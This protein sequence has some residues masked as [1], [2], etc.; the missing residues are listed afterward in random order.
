MLAVSSDELA[1][2]ADNA[3]WYLQ[4]MMINMR[5]RVTPTMIMFRNGQSVYSQGGINENSLRQAVAEFQPALS[6][7]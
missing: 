7:L 1:S 3:A 4:K 6:T 5:V 2:S